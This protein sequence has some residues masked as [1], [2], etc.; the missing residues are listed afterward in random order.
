MEVIISAL[1][2]KK[3][4]VVFPY[5]KGIIDI[6]RKNPQ[7][8]WSITQQSWIIPDNLTYLKFF[9]DCLAKHRYITPIILTTEIDYHRFLPLKIK[10]HLSINQNFTTP[11]QISQLISPPSP[12]SQNTIS[13]QPKDAP[14]WVAQGNQTTQIAQGKQTA[15]VANTTI[16]PPREITPE[17]RAAIDTLT[18][19]FKNA[20]EG[21]H[22]SPR[23]QSAYRT[24]LSRFLKRYAH[25]PARLF[26]NRQLNEFLT[27]LA[28][29]GDVSAST[30]NQALAAL[31]F[32][33]IRV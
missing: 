23:T 2:D 27:S 1:P 11:P 5:N 12:A 21:R 13:V 32:F 29:E 18:E 7:A 20:M 24:W 25:I 30:Q 16:R 17:Q 4:R 14:G 15:Q 19:T 22:Y 6:F 28:V 33:Y 8:R 31:L 9:L 26:T 3:L 10:L